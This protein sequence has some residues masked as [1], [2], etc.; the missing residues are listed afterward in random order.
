MHFNNFF[1]FIYSLIYLFLYLFIPPFIPYGELHF[2]KLY[3]NFK[4]KRLV[5][6]QN[7]RLH[8]MRMLILTITMKA[9]THLDRYDKLQTRLYAT[10]AVT[11]LTSTVAILDAFIYLVRDLYSFIQIAWWSVYAFGHHCV[12]FSKIYRRNAEGS[13]L[14]RELA[15]LDPW[16]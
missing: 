1:V 15:L 2:I 11:V 13:S 3:N 5:L 14:K 9:K 16:P 8:I 12:A 7:N 6:I 10:T 4:A